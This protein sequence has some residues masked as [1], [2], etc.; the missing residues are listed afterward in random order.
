MKSKDLSTFANVW[1]EFYA[2]IDGAQSVTPSE[3]NF[4]LQYSSL[5]SPLEVRE[6]IS[7]IEQQEQSLMAP[8]DQR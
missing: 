6:L 5:F 3:K 7:S 1:E 4:Y 8:S 2:L